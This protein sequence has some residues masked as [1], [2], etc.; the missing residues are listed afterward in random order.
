MKVVFELPK[1]EKSLPS[2][3]LASVTCLLGVERKISND[4]VNILLVK[5]VKLENFS[6]L[7]TYLQVQM[8]ASREGY[9]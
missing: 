9:D 7:V 5:S 4:S 1:A 2:V 3:F 8:L 6:Y